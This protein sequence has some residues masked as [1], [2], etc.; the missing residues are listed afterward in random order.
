MYF[1]LAGPEILLSKTSYTGSKTYI[2]VGA[3]DAIDAQDWRCVRIVNGIQPKYIV[4]TFHGFS[5]GF[6]VGELVVLR[7]C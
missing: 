2:D 5:M 3:D 6:F 1:V 4:F 7:L